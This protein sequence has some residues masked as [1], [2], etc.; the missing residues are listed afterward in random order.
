M[1][2]V[3]DAYTKQSRM[4]MRQNVNNDVSMNPDEKTWINVC[5]WEIVHLPLPKPNI[6]PYF[7]LWAKR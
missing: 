1:T 4:L 7:S 2:G 3:N 6:N 5:F